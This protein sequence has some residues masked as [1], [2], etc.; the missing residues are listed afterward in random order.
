M[1][2]DHYIPQCLTRPWHDARIG[3]RSL[4]VFDFETQEFDVRNSERFFARRGVNQAATEQFL[5]RYI[6]SPF[7]I[8]Q[9]AIRAAAPDEARMQAAFSNIPA[10]A[11][12]GLYWLQVQRIHDA[13]QPRTEYHLDRLANRG[14]EWLEQFAAV[15][16]ERYE[17]IA[18][19]VPTSLYFPDTAAFLVPQLG[20]MPAVALPIDTGLALVFADRR[21]DR[22]HLDR[23]M[24][25]PGNAMACSL[26]F[27]TRTKRVV[28]PPELDQQPV[29]AS[30]LRTRSAVSQ[31]FSLY[32][33]TALAMGL[34]TW[35]LEP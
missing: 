10:T 25:T 33:E 21:A 20:Q 34:S 27:S 31:L 35:Q 28:L 26:G 12:V 7:A 32:S 29:P 5:S 6:E 3:A 19:L 30:L 11:L 24:T 14:P 9:D 22:R 15:V 13:L 17:P 2:L 23:F 8:G 1:P 4:R 16:F 18:Y